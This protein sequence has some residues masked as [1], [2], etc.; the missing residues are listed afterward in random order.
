MRVH[1]EIEAHVGYWALLKHNDRFRR[2]WIAQLISAAGD[3][4]NSVAVLGLVFQLTHSGLGASFV[5]LSS[6][7]P[8][9][10]LIPIAGPVV[11]R[12]DRRNLMI[13]ANLFSA[14]VALLFLLIHDSNMV[15][16]AYLANVLL[17]V[18]ASF[19]IP[20]S[21]ASIPNIVSRSELFS[22]NALSGSTWAIMVMVGSGLGG[23]ISTLFG[24]DIAFIVNS[25]SFVIAA[26]LIATLKI[27]SPKTEKVLTPWKDFAEGLR[28]LRGYLP[29]LSL[30]GVKVGWGL[31]AGTLVL[32][33]VYG[34]QVFKAGDAGIGILYAARGLGAL[35]GPFAIRAIVGRSIKKSRQAIW[36]C[37]LLGMV[38]YSLLAWSGWLNA[39][40]LGCI[41][42]TI[43]H[44]GGGTVWALSNVLLQLTTPDRL[45]GRVLAV[46]N[47]LNTLTTGISTLIFGLSLQVGVLPMILALVGGVIFG[48]Y[49][50][51]WGTGTA[52]GPL[53]LSEN[54]VT[55]SEARSTS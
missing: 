22:A 31:G 43:A 54:T 6:T 50:V 15:W 55:A 14:G 44:F 20:A 47:G 23:I 11:D 29:A 39:I 52:R 46:D 26:V 38:G 4:F 30:V 25:L 17:V 5:L 16:L 10:F 9:F 41:G 37:F 18:S 35:I 40:W 34:Q 13:G 8:M 3:W 12:F 45:R 1:Q 24:R 36:I 21:S 33:T 2:L 53:K 48:L 49:S 42:L 19:F 28:Y 32:L 7:V 51:I 27:P